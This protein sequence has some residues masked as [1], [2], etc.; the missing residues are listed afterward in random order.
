MKFKSF[1]NV[2]YSIVNY[3]YYEM[4]D[5]WGIITVDILS[6]DNR[7]NIDKQKIS[8]WFFHKKKKLSIKNR[9]SEKLLFTSSLKRFSSCL[10]LTFTR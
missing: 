5:Y 2:L 7:I 6:T 8:E 1:L 10:I 4:I 9:N 3:Y